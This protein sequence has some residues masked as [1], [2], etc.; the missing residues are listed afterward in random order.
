MTEVQ[1]KENQTPFYTSARFSVWTLGKKEKCLFSERQNIV[2]PLTKI[3]YNILFLFVNRTNQPT[4]KE[5]IIKHLAKDPEKY[6]GLC[7]C[8]NRLQKKFKLASAGEKLFRSVR[9][10]G[11]C[12]AQVLAHD[13]AS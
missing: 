3:E 12:I 4:S 9:N 2:I 6:Q 11:Y 10:K 7:M 5:V 13:Q 8:I 1:P